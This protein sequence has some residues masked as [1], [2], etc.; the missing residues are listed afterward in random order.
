MGKE[1]GFRFVPGRVG[2]KINYPGERSGAEVAE[3]EPERAR[4]RENV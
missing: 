1:G 3:R 4:E 2:E